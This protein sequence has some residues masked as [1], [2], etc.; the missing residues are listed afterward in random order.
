MNI[1]KFPHCALQI[2]KLE[3]GYSVSN[4]EGHAL[5]KIPKFSILTKLKKVKLGISTNLSGHI[6]LPKLKLT[7]QLL[8]K[9]DCLYLGHCTTLMQNPKDIF[10]NNYPFIFYNDNHNYEIKELPITAN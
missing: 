2:Q 6:F 10:C 8:L 7:N 1:V 5:Q 4:L 9:K 3:F